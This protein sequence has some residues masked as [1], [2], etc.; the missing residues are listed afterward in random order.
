MDESGEPGRPAELDALGSPHFFR[1]ASPESKHVFLGEYHHTIDE[2]G[3]ISIPVKFRADF[4]RGAVITRGLDGSLFLF[5]SEEWDKLA[6][7]I[8][9]LPLGK[10][11]TRA[12]ARL[13]LAGAMDAVLDKQGRVVI[14]EYLRDYAAVQKNAVVAGLYNRLEIWDAKRWESYKQQTEKDA[15]ELAEQLGELG[16]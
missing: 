6:G 3:R 9:T 13:M 4:E 8:A 10:A 5:P 11:N 15:V 1:K 14:P 7:K 16:L 2:K 12:F